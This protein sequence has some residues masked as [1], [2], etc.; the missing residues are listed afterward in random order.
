MDSELQYVEAISFAGD[1]YQTQAS[2]NTGCLS[3]ELYSKYVIF[4]HNKIN[5]S[6]KM[7]SVI[8]CVYSPGTAATKAAWNQIGKLEV[9][10]L[11]I[12]LVPLKRKNKNESVP[13]SLY[14][15]TVESTV[16]SQKEKKK[17]ANNPPHQDIWVFGLQFKQTFDIWSSTSYSSQNMLSIS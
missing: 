1:Q 13:S 4:N 17:Q 16:K 12:F 14:S 7:L 6:V 2:M 3:Q 9:I 11:P 15:L 5:K 8:N 10:L